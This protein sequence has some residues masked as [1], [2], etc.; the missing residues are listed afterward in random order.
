MFV[1]WEHIG[2]NNLNK[3]IF[4]SINEN[5]YIYKTVYSGKSTYATY[6]CVFNND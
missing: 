4:Q 5:R 3:Y 6:D 2:E 1:V